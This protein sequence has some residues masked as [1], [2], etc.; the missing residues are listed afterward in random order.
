MPL[1]V[2]SRETAELEDVTAAAGEVQVREEVETSTAGATE[3]PNM[4]LMEA[5]EAPEAPC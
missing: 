2:I 5:P 4:Q 3:S 1:V